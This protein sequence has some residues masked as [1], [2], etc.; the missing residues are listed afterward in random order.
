M[1][2]S[3]QSDRNSGGR[4]SAREVELIRFRDGKVPV[5]FTLMTDE[6]IEGVV[7]WYDDISVHVVMADRSEVTIMNNVIS[8]Y[9]RR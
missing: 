9:G 7:I 5:K 2:I 1:E 4:V 8:K 3:S 6:V